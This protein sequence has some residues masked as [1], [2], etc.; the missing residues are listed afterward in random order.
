MDSYSKNSKNWSK[1]GWIEQ[2]SLF[3]KE[4]E[5]RNDYVTKFESCMSLVK[6]KKKDESLET[7]IDMVM[8]DRIWLWQVGYGYGKMG[9]S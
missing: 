8:A 2:A 4:D 9:R 1:K 3:H 5:K 6:R 7:A